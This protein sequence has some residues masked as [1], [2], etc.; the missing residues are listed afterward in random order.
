MSAVD[1]LEFPPKD[2]KVIIAAIKPL[3]LF[4]WVIGAS[5]LLIYSQIVDNQLQ[6][7]ITK[8]L[9]K[10]VLLVAPGS[11]PQL[12][13][14]SG[15][16]KLLQ[17]SELKQLGYP[18]KNNKSLLIIE[19]LNVPIPLTNLTDSL[20]YNNFIPNNQFDEGILISTV[21][22]LGDLVNNAT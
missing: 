1:F 5:K 3:I 11:S 13:E 20:A 19:L 6:M 15:Q 22:T 17:P 2:T 9:A 10:Y 16:I 14:L 7:D 12:Y 4:D 18:I 21:V 8:L